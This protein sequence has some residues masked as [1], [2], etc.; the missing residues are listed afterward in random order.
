MI[1]NNTK[2]FST[3]AVFVFTAGKLKGEI[4][5]LCRTAIANNNVNA[6]IRAIKTGEA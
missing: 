2:L 6:L 4:A 5:S 3:L 1:R